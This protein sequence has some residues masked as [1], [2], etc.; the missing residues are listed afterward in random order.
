MTVDEN[1]NEYPKKETEPK[2]QTVDQ[3]ILNPRIFNETMSKEIGSLAGAMAKAQGEMNNGVKDKQGYNYKY[4]TL[5]ALT[6]IIRKPLSDNGL[7]LMQTHEVHKGGIGPS[8]LVHTTLVHESGQWFKSSL[9]MP[10]VKMPQLSGPQQIGISCT[11]GRRYALQA[12]CMIAS[13]EDTDA[14]VK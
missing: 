14:S 12:L 13:E 11:Y 9:E 10:I 6:D 4:M 8:V 7:A 3:K 2:K 1:K 5:D